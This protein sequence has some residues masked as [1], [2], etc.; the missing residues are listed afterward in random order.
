MSSN[1]IELY[2]WVLGDQLDQISLVTIDKT[3]TIIHLRAAIKLEKENG[4]RDHD[5]DTLALWRFPVT[6]EEVPI[7]LANTNLDTLPD[8]DKLRSLHGISQVFP[9][10][11]EDG[12]FYLVIVQPGGEY[13]LSMWAALPLMFHS[14]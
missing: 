8:R 2:V 6:K 14:V 3:Q 5:A 12:R 1:T 7:R 11:P 4:L 13:W 9:D 10:L